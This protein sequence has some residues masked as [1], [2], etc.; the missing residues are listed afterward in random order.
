MLNFHIWVWHKATIAENTG[1]KSRITNH[2]FKVKGQK[3]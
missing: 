2:M 3:Y 1:A